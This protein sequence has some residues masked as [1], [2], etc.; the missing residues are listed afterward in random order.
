MRNARARGA[1]A[2]VAAG[3]A[4][5]ADAR[6]NL[7]AQVKLAFFDIL[8]RQDEAKLAAENQALL[9][10]IRNR[11]KLRV[12][13]GESPRYEL[14]K[15]EAELMMAESA[16]QT[17]EIRVVQARDKLRALSAAPPNQAFEIVHTMS[18]SPHC[19]N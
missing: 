2:G 11:V 15:S 14:V 13:V 16:A 8:R 17:A 9:L 19:L 4:L 6:I 10:Q 18:V 3:A 5:L 7:Y 1:Q 12:E